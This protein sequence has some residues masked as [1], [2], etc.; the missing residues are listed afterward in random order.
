M[1][2]QIEHLPFTVAPIRSQE[3]LHDVC[4]LR[5]KAYGRH[6]PALAETLKVPDHYDSNPRCAVFV[7]RHKLDNT[8]LGTMRIHLADENERLP[9]EQSVELPSHVRNQLRI[10]ATRLAVDA[11]E[12]APLVKL[13]LFK[14]LY[15]YC[16]DRDVK[17]M[18]I[19]ARSPL[20]KQYANLVFEYLFDKTAKPMKH[21]N[22]IPHYC[23]VFN[24]LT[25]KEVWGRCQ[26][27][28]FD[29]MYNTEHPDI[30]VR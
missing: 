9:L 24:V 11:N 1:E 6:L 8:V 12:T 17:W 21:A 2:Q 10:E 4:A 27:P 23:L 28:L 5:Y 13:A 14:G 16:L 22:N 29:F 18:V 19:A 30:S 25:S 3:D 20:D 7:A 15:L 26:H